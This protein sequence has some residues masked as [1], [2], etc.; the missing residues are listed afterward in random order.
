MVI[1]DIGENPMALLQQAINTIIEREG[2]NFVDGV[3][4]EVDLDMRDPFFYLRFRD[5]TLAVNFATGETQEL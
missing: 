2:G 4:V 3:E 5:S 1:T